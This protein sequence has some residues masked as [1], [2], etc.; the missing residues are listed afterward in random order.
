MSQLDDVQQAESLVVLEQFRN[1]AKLWT[2][3]DTKS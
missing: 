1:D 2:E 3:L